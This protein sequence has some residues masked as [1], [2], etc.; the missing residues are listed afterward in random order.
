MDK[1]ED[2]YS[3]CF[4]AQN[5]GHFLGNFLYELDDIYNFD[6]I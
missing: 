4:L 6:N 5:I 2:N 1:D 3:I